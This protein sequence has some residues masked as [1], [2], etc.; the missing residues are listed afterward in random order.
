MRPVRAFLERSSG[1]LATAGA[2]VEEEEAA[3]GGDEPAISA[4]AAAPAA[5]AAAEGPSGGELKEEEQ[6]GGSSSAPPPPSDHAS[7]SSATSAAA[8]ALRLVPRLGSLLRDAERIASMPRSPRTD[9]RPIGMAVRGGGVCKASGRGG[10]QRRGQGTAPPQPPCRSESPSPSPSLQ[11]F[12][13]ALGEVGASVNPES[14][15]VHELNEWNAQARSRGGAKQG[16]AARLASLAGS[17]LD[18][19]RFSHAH[20]WL[21]CRLPVPLPSTVWHHRQ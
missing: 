16:D 10:G 14:G 4:Q 15:A 12:E 13:A 5:P 6:A 18:A 20:L 17:L 9:L 21:A 7:A 1:A 3:E 2:E 19:R 11:D 8:S